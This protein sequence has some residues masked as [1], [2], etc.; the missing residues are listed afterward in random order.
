MQL[1]P[2]AATTIVAAFALGLAGCSMSP[3]ATE[4]AAETESSETTETTE[5]TETGETDAAEGGDAADAPVEGWPAEV[6]VPPGEM[7][8]DASNGNQTVVVFQVDDAGAA[9]TYAADLEAA[10]FS[11]MEEGTQE[12]AGVVANVYQGSGH[13][14][15]VSTVEAGDMVM[16][17]VAIQPL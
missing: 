9:D 3:P 5:G 13:I 15:A 16:L 17:S 7:Q 2:I 11:P 14:V 12:I 4:P 6:P 10:G 8:Q 1:R